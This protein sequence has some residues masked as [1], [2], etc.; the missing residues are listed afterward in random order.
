MDSATICETAPRWEVARTEGLDYFMARHMAS[1]LGRFLQPDPGG[2]LLAYATNP[3]SWHL[4]SYVWNNPL[5]YVDPTGLDV[6]QIGNCYF[7]VTRDP[8]TGDLTSI[9]SSGFCQQP[10]QPPVPQTP[11]TP[12]PQ[13]QNPKVANNGKQIGMC[14]LKGAAV[15]AVGGALAV[16]AVAVGAPVAAVTGVL[17]VLAVAGGAAFGIDVFQ[18][19]RASN[20]AG[21][22]YD[23]GSAAGG[24]A[25]GYFGGGTIANGIKSPAS[26]GWSLSRDLQNLYNP[27]LGSF[28]QFLGTGPDAGAAGGAAAMSGAGAAAAVKRG[29]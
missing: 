12:P 27:S 17:G 9:E 3:Q 5:A 14:L 11:A 4:Y 28:G 7:N 1:G 20:W 19:F 8:E 16:G 23:V 29:C 22:A 2:E 13:T 10:S 24:A 6:E 18:Q 15:G 21:V 25:A 26:S